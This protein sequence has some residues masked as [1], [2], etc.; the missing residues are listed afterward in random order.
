MSVIFD[1]VG[2][3]SRNEFIWR[4]GDEYHAFLYR[5]CETSIWGA[6]DHLLQTKGR[7]ANVFE[8]QTA[9]GGL[10]TINAL[11]IAQHVLHSVQRTVTVV[12]SAVAADYLHAE[13]SPGH[14]SLVTV[15][16]TVI[17]VSWHIWRI[18]CILPS[19]CAHVG[20]I[21]AISFRACRAAVSAEGVSWTV[22]Q[23]IQNVGGGVFDDRTDMSYVC[24]SM[25]KIALAR[26]GAGT[27][28]SLGMTGQTLGLTA[29]SANVP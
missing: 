2:G 14:L 3:S 23:R 18:I 17:F 15:F 10:T 26:R 12:F 6:N 9:A 27:R 1:L 11:V 25:E 24:R 20:I 19:L 28:L 7:L 8:K 5:C 29:T 16:E 22:A 21:V 4:H 13:S